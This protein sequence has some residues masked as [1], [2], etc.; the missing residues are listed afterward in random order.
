[1]LYDLSLKESGRG[2]SIYFRRSKH[3]PHSET[4]LNSRTLTALSNDSHDH[5]YLSL[6]HF[7]IGAQA[8]LKLT[9]LMCL[10]GS[11]AG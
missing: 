11:L 6:R 4:L 8:F 1:M 7:L 2:H 10:F 5:T 3:S 9:C